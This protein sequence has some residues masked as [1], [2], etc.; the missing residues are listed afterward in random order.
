MNDRMNGKE[1][2]SLGM[3][4]RAS[5]GLLAAGLLGVG[6][7]GSGALVGCGNGEEP[8]AQDVRDDVA[9]AAETAGRFAEQ[10]FDEARAWFDERFSNA[11][12]ELEQLRAD[13]EDLEGEARER[14]DAAIDDLAERWNALRAQFE[15][16][17][18]DGGDAWRAVADGLSDSWNEFRESLDEAKEEFGG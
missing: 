7:L 3:L 6:V 4:R 13:A 14:A 15:Q 9:D 2:T 16:M 8:T 18:D 10:R 17:E 1:I 12:N 11:E 5:G